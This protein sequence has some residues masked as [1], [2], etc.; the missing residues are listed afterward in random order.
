M[1]FY[2]LREGDEDIYSDLVLV[3]DDEMSPADFFA[4]VGSIREGIVDS[5]EDDTL[6]E[7]IATVLERDHDF[8]HVSDERLV[9]SVNVS[10]D[11]DDTYL[12]EPSETSLGADYRG[13]IADWDP[14]TEGPVI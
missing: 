11:A 6:I 7:A 10:E 2:E 4:L 5:Y 9:A 14:E 8:V 13:I 3:R 1:Y 12:V